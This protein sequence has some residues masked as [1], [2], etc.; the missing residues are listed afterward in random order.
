M[1]GGQLA[2]E[3]DPVNAIMKWYDEYVDYEYYNQT[4]VP[5]KLC[6]HY[7]QVNLIFHLNF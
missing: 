6:G 2:M 5:G 7:T 1:G 3:F 4:C